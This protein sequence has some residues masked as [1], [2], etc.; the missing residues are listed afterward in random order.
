MSPRGGWGGGG[1]GRE[2]THT[3]KPVEMQEPQLETDSDIPY[4]QDSPM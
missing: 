3:M 2:D 4:A 1:A